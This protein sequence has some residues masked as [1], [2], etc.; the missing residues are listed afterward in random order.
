MALTEAEKLAIQKEI[1]EIEAKNEGIALRIGD[2]LRRRVE[3]ADLFEEINGIKNQISE[4]QFMTSKLKEVEEVD[5][6]DFFENK[7]SKKEIDE[8]EIEAV[9]KLAEEILAK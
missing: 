2:S 7:N 6:E 3:K 1:E 8:V 5:L 9:F 4:V